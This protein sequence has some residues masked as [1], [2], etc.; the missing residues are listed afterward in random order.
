MHYRNGKEA[1]NGDTIVQ[2]SDGRITAFGVLYNA[3]PGND[4]CNGYIAPISTSQ[5]C[6]CLCDCLCM[7]DIAEMLK[8]KGLD[9]RPEGK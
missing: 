3:T 9:K 2:I 6:A 8:E 5:P 1:K 4:F 7:D